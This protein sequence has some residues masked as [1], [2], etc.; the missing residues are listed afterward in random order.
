MFCLTLAQIVDKESATLNL[1]GSLEKRVAMDADHSSICKFDSADTPACKL[2]V[3]TIATEFECSLRF[4]RMQLENLK[5]LLYIADSLCSCEG[6]STCQ[7]T[8][9]SCR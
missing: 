6:A 2:V 3:E 9:E 8:S 7:S 1:P 4:E 5:N